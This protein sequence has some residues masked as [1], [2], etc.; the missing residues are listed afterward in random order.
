LFGKETS[1][2]KQSKKF[3]REVDEK[4]FQR[5]KKKW[6]RFFSKKSKFD[7]SARNNQMIK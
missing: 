3:K 1:L 5:V 4:D 2:K 6:H 7:N